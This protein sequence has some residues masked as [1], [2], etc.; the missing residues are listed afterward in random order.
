LKQGDVLATVE[1]ELIYLPPTTKAGMQ[2]LWT[3]Q[4]AWLVHML[5]GAFYV[6]SGSKLG[7]GC[8]PSV[9]DTNSGTFHKLGCELIRR[10]ANRGML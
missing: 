2:R 7:F 6:I 5:R 10:G 4:H 8:W 9:W 3:G 1:K